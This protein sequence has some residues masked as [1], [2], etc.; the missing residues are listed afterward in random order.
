MFWLGQIL[1]GNLIPFVLIYLPQT[2]NCRA[3]LSIACALVI[4]GGL[5]QIYV[6]IIGG[7][8]YPL[9]LFPGMEVSSSFFDGVVADYAPSV[10]EVLLGVGG[11]AISLLLVVV[12]IAVLDFLPESLS[13]SVIAKKP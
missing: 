7:Q 6:I 10:W 9:E 8:A 12:G 5:A 2:K 11:I 13:D 4:L 1:I 3:T